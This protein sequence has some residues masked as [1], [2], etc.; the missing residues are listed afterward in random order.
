MDGCFEEKDGG[1]NKK[2]SVII[3]CYNLKK[4]VIAGEAD[5]GET[6]FDICM[7]SVLSQTIGLCNMEIILV[8]DA[9]TDDGYTSNVLRTYE[10]MFPEQVLVVLLEEN[11]RQGGA[12]NIGLS[13]AT[14]E[15]VAF[16]D[17]DDWVSE[18]L[19]ERVY[20]KA[21]DT[22][23]DMVYFF[24]EAVQGRIRVPM[25]DL[26]IPE[27]HCI[28]SD[29]GLRKRFLLSPLVDY[30]CTTK[31]YRRQLLV[32]TGVCF[33]H[34]LI[35]EEPAFTYPLMFYVECYAV[36]PEILY[37]YRI[38]P[39]STMNTSHSFERLKNHPIVQ[40]MLFREMAERG[41][42]KQYGEEIQYH[43]LHSYFY[44]TLLF[45]ANQDVQIPIDFYREMQDTV[46]ELI[47]EWRKNRYL[48]SD[49]DILLARVLDVGLDRNFSQAG[50]DRFGQQVKE[51]SGQ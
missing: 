48:D 20:Q 28:L 51:W 50:L 30:R 36:V 39:N 29:A 25:D 34:H 2:I 42:V 19:Y 1:M 13:Y 49:G 23:A 3:P 6:A 24:H 17:A 46:M 11:Q 40:L 31:L 10:Q 16:L 27:S 26:S 33:P 21:V 18:N 32:D 14:G 8:D 44:E 41:F 43:F 22:G 9:S 12:R 15:Y 37:H 47:P 45:A 35:Y 7:Q 38:N 4:D 5:S